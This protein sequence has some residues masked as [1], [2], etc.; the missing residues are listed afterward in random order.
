M[1]AIVSELNENT[2]L[3]DSI[4]ISIRQGRAIKS[5]LIWQSR[6]DSA[7]AVVE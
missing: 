3:L 1:K 2:A 6:A 4:Y 5:P 7:A